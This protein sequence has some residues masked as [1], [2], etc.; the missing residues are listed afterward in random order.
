MSFAGFSDLNW[1]AVLVAAF[2]YFILGAGWYN[3][4]AFGS[5]WMRS[6]GWDPGARPTMGAVAYVGPLV[7]YLAISISLGLLAEATAT[8][9][10][11]E[12]FILGLIV[13]LG[14]VT[15]IILVTA[16]FD[17]MKPQPMTWFAITA[18]YHYIGILIAA[19]I[20]GA[21]Q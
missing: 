2:V 19:M 10:L 14:I 20:I 1:W 12:G 21:W 7:A 17:P 4:S 15:A 6:I 11:L 9:T 5:R 18:G 3:P 16:V 8:D 13:G